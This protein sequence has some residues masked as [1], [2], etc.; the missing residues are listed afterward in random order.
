VRSLGVLY[1]KRATCFRLSALRPYRR[2]LAD[3]K[4]MWPPKH[5][6]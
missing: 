2:M 1:A 6:V 4:L 5:A 3:R